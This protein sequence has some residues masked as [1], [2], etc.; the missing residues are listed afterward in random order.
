MIMEDARAS[1][2]AALVALERLCSSHPW[3]E[4][5]LASALSGRAGERIVG[6]RADDG[7]QELLGF[8][9]FRAVADEVEIHDVA[10][11]P[12]RRRQGLA[13]ALLVRAIALA[14][15]SG[16]LVAHLEVRAG[17]AAA[18]GLYCQLGFEPVGRRPGYYTSPEEDALLFSAAIERV[19]AAGR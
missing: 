1:D 5:M 12:S 14:A 2:L 6:A 3:S 17:N 18:I 19:L 7:S 4:T 11:D 15:A 16:A 13:R 10:V 8:C 9:L